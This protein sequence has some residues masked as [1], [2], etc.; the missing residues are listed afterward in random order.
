MNKS[1]KGPWAVD[2]DGDPIGPRKSALGGSGQQRGNIPAVL[3]ILFV[4]FL[5]GLALGACGAGIYVPI[6]LVQWL[7][8]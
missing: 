5:C 3:T 4:M 8:S 2:G 7:F 1:S 6:K